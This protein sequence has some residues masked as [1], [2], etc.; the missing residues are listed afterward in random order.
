MKRNQFEKITRTANVRRPF[1]EIAEH[2][3]RR[4]KYNKAQRIARSTW[5]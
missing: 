3:K 1:E 4:G 5:K 2:R